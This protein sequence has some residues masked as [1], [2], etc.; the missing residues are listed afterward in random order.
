[1]AGISPDAALKALIKIHGGSSG[2]W[3]AAQPAASPIAQQLP[4]T[5]S[6]CKTK[7]NHATKCIVASPYEFEPSSITAADRRHTALTTETRSPPE[8]MSK[9]GRR[10]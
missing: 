10:D 1:M 2:A 3:A 6:A 4:T 9:R 7:K 8:I 5:I